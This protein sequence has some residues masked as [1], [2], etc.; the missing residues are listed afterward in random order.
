MKDESGLGTG[1]GWQPL[2][3]AHLLSL[4]APRDWEGAGSLRDAVGSTG[5]SLTGRVHCLLRAVQTAGRELT[6]SCL[7]WP[8]YLQGMPRARGRLRAQS[9]TLG[10]GSETACLV[11]VMGLYLLL[12]AYSCT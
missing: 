3:F 5:T 7:W 4:S 9:G 10:R 8:G 2:G 6:A 1:S 12:L 11:V